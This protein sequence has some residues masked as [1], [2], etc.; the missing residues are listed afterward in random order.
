MT[1]DEKQWITHDFDA[2]ALMRKFKKT[3]TLDEIPETRTEGVS[4]MIHKKTSSSV[5]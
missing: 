2:R 1:V 5:Q 3:Q 4:S